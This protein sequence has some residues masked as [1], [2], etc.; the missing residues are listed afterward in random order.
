MVWISVYFHIHSSQVNLGD[1]MD[2]TYVGN[3]KERKFDNGGAVI[4][5]TLDLDMLIKE[6]NNHGFLSNRGVRKIKIDV[7][8]RRSVGEYGDTHSVTTNTW[9]PESFNKPHSVS[10]VLDKKESLSINPEDDI[11]F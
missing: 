9:H 4:S 8:T 10:L 6:Y 11:P 3:G 2:K 1:L 5:V 7:S